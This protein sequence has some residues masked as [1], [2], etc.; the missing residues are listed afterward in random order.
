MSK[1]KYSEIEMKQPGGRHVWGVLQME[2][3]TDQANPETRADLRIGLAA[4]RLLSFHKQQRDTEQHK[5]RDV[6][7]NR[8]QVAADRRNHE[9]DER[10][11]TIT[12]KIGLNIANHLG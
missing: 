10:K 6:H 3:R 4:R 1:A 2:G 9:V 8:H 12:R 5:M 11:H 7:R